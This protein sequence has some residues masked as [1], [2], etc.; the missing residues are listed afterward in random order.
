LAAGGFHYF[1]QF[2]IN[3]LKIFT[4]GG[5]IPGVH[6]AKHSEKQGRFWFAAE[7]LFGEFGGFP[8]QSFSAAWYPR[9]STELTAF[10]SIGFF[11][12]RVSAKNVGKPLATESVLDD[13]VNETSW[14]QN[15]TS[16]ISGRDLD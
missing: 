13:S 3:S 5:S 16:W 10:I 8:L 14:N 7:V 4:R 15:G 6:F 12:R 9:P 11:H 1:G 2:D